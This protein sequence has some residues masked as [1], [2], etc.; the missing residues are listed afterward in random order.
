MKLSK[1]QKEEFL[2]V[3]AKMSDEGKRLNACVCF[4]AESAHENF[5][6][7]FS[8][9]SSE[10]STSSGGADSGVAQTNE[11]QSKGSGVFVAGVRR[12]IDKLRAAGRIRRVGPDK[13]GHWEVIA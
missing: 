7:W 3:V 5:P 1:E 13:G 12:V 11:I 6:E 4:G 8:E 9:E 2:R 10:V